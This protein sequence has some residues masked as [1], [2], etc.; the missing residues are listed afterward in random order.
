MRKSPIESATKFPI[1]TRKMG[2][3]GN[4][5][6]ILKDKNGR[7]RWAKEGCWF[8]IYEINLSSKIKE[9]T[10]NKLPFDWFWV[11]AGS[12]KN[13]KYPRE[14]QFMGRPDKSENIK[15]YLSKYFTNLKT[16]CIINHFRI[17]K[18]LS[19]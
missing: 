2:L 17:V 13:L 12:T 18:T 7:K 6:Y 5:Y 11:G 19:S 9:W 1:N 4:I 8:V 15:E 14:E 3:D 16:K 10:Y